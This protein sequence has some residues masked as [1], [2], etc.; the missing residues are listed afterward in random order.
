MKAIGR[1]CRGNTLPAILSYEEE[2]GIEKQYF[3]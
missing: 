3:V 2:I 1:G